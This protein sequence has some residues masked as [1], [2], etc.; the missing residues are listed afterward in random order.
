MCKYEIIW[1]NWFIQDKFI[2]VNG[3]L[4]QDNDIMILISDIMRSY[5]KIS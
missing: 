3:E 4:I 5:E 2:L 1:E